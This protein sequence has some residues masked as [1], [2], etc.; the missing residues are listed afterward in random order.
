[1]L[2]KIFGE[3]EEEEEEEESEKRPRKDEQVAAGTTAPMA[4]VKTK[5]PGKRKR[6]D[7]S[8]EITSA[9][10]PS[11]PPPPL[12]AVL[13]PL[14]PPPEPVAPP[15]LTPPL[16]TKEE[17]KRPMFK[18]RGEGEEERLVRE[19]VKEDSLDK[20]DIAMLRLAL[21]RLREEGA[22]LVGGVNW[23]HHPHDILPFPLPLS[24]CVCCFPL[25]FC[26]LDS[27]H[28]HLELRPPNG[29]VVTRHMTCWF[30]RQVAQDLRDTTRL[31]PEIRSSISLT[32]GGN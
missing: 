7:G 24:V 15:T 27:A 11:S 8:P 5:K 23:A 18:P 4:S 10:P 22:G 9:A 29:D 31:M 32:T 21:R 13:R 25:D 17:P 16:P 28:F 2:Q 3:S 1:M 19:T 14:T 26:F 20:E 12:T 30:M 6:E